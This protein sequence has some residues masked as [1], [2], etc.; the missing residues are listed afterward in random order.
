MYGPQ[1]Y[2]LFFL[3]LALFLGGLALLGTIIE[4]QENRKAK[5][6]ERQLHRLNRR[7]DS[8]RR[9][10]NY[11]AQMQEVLESVEGRKGA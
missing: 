5:R 2:I 8:H 3:A 7:E 10:A 11:L 6:Q 9:H 1:D 4:W